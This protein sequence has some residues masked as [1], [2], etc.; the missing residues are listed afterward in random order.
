MPPPEQMYSNTQINI[1]SDLPDILKQ[2]TK[3]A[4]RT[5]PPDVLAWSAAYFTALSN[6]ETLPVKR[7]LEAPGSG[8]TPGLL[9]MV[10]NQFKDNEEVEVKTIE[11]KWK[12][13]GL[14]TEEI[15]DI[16]KSGSFQDSC[17]LIHFTAMGASHL[18]GGN[19]TEAMRMVCHVLTKDADGG[20]NRIPFDTFK[21][22]YEYLIQVKGEDSS[23]VDT[24]IAY[25]R[26]EAD[27]QDGMVM[28]RNFLHPDCPS[29]S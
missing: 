19:V 13:M 2:F 3:S 11:K 1:P 8:L 4:I 16:I 17:K 29:L 20:A 9:D 15:K 25:L 7:R 14:P 22:I 23:Q 24:V 12:E 27:R 28:P 10:V 18:G 26:D 21:T 5:Q 6:G